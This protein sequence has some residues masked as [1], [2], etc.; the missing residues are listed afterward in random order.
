MKTR[1]TLMGALVIALLGTTSAVAQ[2]PPRPTTNGAPAGQYQAQPG[3]DSQAPSYNQAPAYSQAPAYNQ[4][5]VDPMLAGPANTGYVDEQAYA[6]QQQQ[7]KGE[8]T[9][10]DRSVG[11]MPM[12]TTQDAWSKPFDNMSPGQKAPGVVRFQWSPDLIMPIRI[13]DYMTTMIVLP[14]WEEAIDFYIGES[15]YMQGTIVR[16]NVVGIRSS[17]SGIDT[18]LTV[19]GKSGSLYTFY[20]RAESYNTRKITDINVFVEVPPSA[21]MWKNNGS[22]PLDFQRGYGGQSQMAP[23]PGG[24]NRGPAAGPYQPASYQQN[25]YQQ[26]SYTQPDA[27]NSGSLVPRESMIFNMTMYEVNKGDSAIAPEYVYS[28]GVW[29]YFHYADRGRT[30]DRPVVYR[31]VDGVESRINTRTAGRYGEVLIAE[32][33]GNF[34]LR[35]GAK[36][37][38]VKRNDTPAG[39]P[40]LPQNR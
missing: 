38:C 33:V 2:I 29:T 12:G 19:V 27:V 20:V 15:F 36:T 13:R 4:A 6:R 25:S 35:N 17:Q 24:M 39:Q 14:E 5:P 26:P 21:G 22:S 3:Y 30:V 28:D 31:V 9:P 10:I 11:G 18:T 32:G 1:N 8:Y 16:S 23:I 40:T 37:I 34:V 7:A